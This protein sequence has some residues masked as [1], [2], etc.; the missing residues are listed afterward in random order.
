[1]VSQISPVICYCFCFCCALRK[2]CGH[3]NRRRQIQRAQR[4][5]EESKEEASR[6][7]KNDECGGLARIPSFE[8]RCGTEGPCRSAK[9]HSYRSSS[10]SRPKD[11]FLINAVTP[12]IAQVFGLLPDTG[13]MDLETTEGLHFGLDILFVHYE[14]E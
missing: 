14:K 11:Y 7:T 1:V 3:C 13:R 10:L 12:P 8:N 4:A 6:C 2:L 5:G 9:A